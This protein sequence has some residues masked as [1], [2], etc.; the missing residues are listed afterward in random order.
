[1]AGLSF[2]PATGHSCECLELDGS[3]EHGHISGGHCICEDSWEE[4]IENCDK[5]NWE[6]YRN[7]LNYGCAKA[8]EITENPDLFPMDTRVAEYSFSNFN[9]LINFD[10]AYLN[11]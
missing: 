10:Y 5:G 3:A 1:M 6:I 4:I 8:V 9:N 7:C 11:K 2:G